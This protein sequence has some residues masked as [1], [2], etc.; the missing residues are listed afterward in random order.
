[1]ADS[2]VHRVVIVGSGF[3]G[4]FAAT[5]LSDCAGNRHVDAGEPTAR[6]H[7]GHESHRVER[8]FSVGHRD[9]RAVPADRRGAR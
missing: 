9:D 2:P 4:L 8:R 7:V 5:A 1:M 6:Q 3:G